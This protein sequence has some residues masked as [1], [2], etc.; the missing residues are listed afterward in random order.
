VLGNDREIRLIWGIVP[1]TLNIANILWG[2]RK[3]ESSENP[4]VCLCSLPFFSFFFS[5]EWIEVGY[6]SI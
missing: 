6:K 1:A 3:R 4:H 2:K 5:S